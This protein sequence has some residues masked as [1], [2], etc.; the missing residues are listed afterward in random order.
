MAHPLLSV[1][2]PVYDPPLDALRE[3]IDSVREQSFSSWE[4]ILADDRSTDPRVRE[5]LRAE[6]ARDPRI[7]VV[8]R[9]RNGGIVAASNS[10][11][12]KARGEFVALLDHDD[13]LVPRAFE[14]VVAW[15]ST[16]PEADYL[17]S[18]EDKVDEAGR[19]YD[20]F[21]KPD[22]S[23]ERLRGQMYTSHLSVLRTSLV[24]QVGGFRDGFEG[25]Q[26]HDLV[27]RV[28]EQARQVLHVPEIL[29]HWRAHSGSTAADYGVKSHAWDA[30]RRA[31]QDHLDRSGI[32]ARA[33]LGELPG[34][35]RLE[36]AVAAGTRVSVIIPTRGSSGLVWGEQ[37]AFVTECVRSLLERTGAE[38][39]VE[40]VVVHDDDT[41]PEVLADLQAIAGGRLVLAPFSRPFNFSEK[42][43]AGYLAASGDVL[44]FL[45]DDIRISSEHF[46]E[47]LVAP[48]SEPDV[49]LTG[50]RLLFADG[51]LQ[52]G[53]H[54]YSRGDITH[55]FLGVKG[56]W[57]GPFSELTINRECS[58]QTA[59]AAAVRREVFEEAGGFCEALPGNFNDVDFSR[60]IGHLGYRT[61]WVAAASAYHF[62]SRTRK[63][64][65]HEWEYRF[66]TTRWDFGGD[67]P[68]MPVALTRSR[69]SEGEA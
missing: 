15:L 23:P 36:R 17:Y 16:H 6:A 21:H 40:I 14:I 51:T 37:D 62:E 7:V 50:A 57:G 64:T 69:R 60:K 44:V 52:H 54:Q 29:Y 43:N 9:E 32:D 13:L 46:L 20:A 49:G 58:G 4:L 56:T 48:L 3:M 18:D 31:V 5:V 28:T 22:W 10:A 33:H 41:P 68:Y 59:A 65:V 1:L 19:F 24:R 66:I 55:V 42:C 2:T 35:Y 26:D 30:G 12:G 61:V 53:G 11:L 47:S 39:D 25:S 34:T 38:L 45:N 67:D 8:E 63:P 27:L